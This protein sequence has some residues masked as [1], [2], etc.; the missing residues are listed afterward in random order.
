VTFISERDRSALMRESRRGYII[1]QGI[2]AAYWRRTS[3]VPDRPALIFTGGMKYEPNHDAA[4]LL[5]REVF[6]RLRERCPAATLEVVG[7]DPQP[8]LVREAQFVEGVTVTGAVADMRPYL[9]R[10]SIFI[11]PL[12]FA[13]GTQ[14]KV[15]EAMAMELPVITT[16]A[17]AEGLRTGAAKPPVLIAN[18]TDEFVNKAGLLLHH[19]D[20]RAE[21]GELGREYVEHHFDWEAT[22]AALEN[23]LASAVSRDCERIAAITIAEAC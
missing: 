19:R 22:G 21:L 23:V 15:L 4:M 10:A 1:K 6:P 16:P 9:E 13:S 3:R 17:V 7:C 8:A 20:R 14:N 12:R 11:A 18:T 2:D 5:V